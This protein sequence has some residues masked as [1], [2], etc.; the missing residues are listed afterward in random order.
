MRRGEY[1]ESRRGERT[2]TAL[3]PR[4]LL[5]APVAVLGGA[6]QVLADL[7][8][9]AAAGGYEPYPVFLRPGPLV[10]R[11]RERQIPHRVIDAGRMRQVR[12]GTRAALWLRH[13]IHRVGPR[14]IVGTE[15]RAHLYCAASAWRTGVPVVWCQPS[16]PKEGDRLT[17]LIA[18]LPA[19][20]VIAPSEAVATRQ[21]GFARCPPVTVV[22]PGVSV[23]ELERASRTTV[24][25]SAG[26]PAGA[27]LVGIVGRLQR[28]KG[29]HLFLCAA[30]LVLEKVP[31]A[32]FVV[33]G[34][35]DM[36]WERGNYPAELRALTRSLGIDERV[37][38]TG[39]SDRPAGWIAALD[40]A[41]NASNPEPFGLVVIEA[42]ALGVT[43]VALAAGGPGEI[44]TDS[45]D[46][47]L[48]GSHN[49]EAFARVIVD[50]LCDGDL[51]ARIG[52]AARSTVH[53]RY[54][55]EQFAAAF[56]S[57]MQHVAKGGALGAD[58]DRS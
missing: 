32:W 10:D 28:W 39:H 30:K 1:R 58:F 48:V 15:P 56:G 14:V 13:E 20:G 44:I 57:L 45:V 47:L 3:L 38:F 8:E 23:D 18:A 33:V 34:G 6:G 46:G 49:P 50:A 9:N 7:V 2:V 25:A 55:S 12:H 51:R 52:V 19:S 4:I 27:P 35:A 21:R 54:T 40:I 42:M 11:F 36:G 17:R 41:V 31:E 22:S 26:I 37:V 43:V 24:R 16:L 53:R 29:Q 5:V